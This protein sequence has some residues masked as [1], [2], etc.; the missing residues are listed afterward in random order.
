MADTQALEQATN[1]FIEDAERVHKIVNGD[2]TESVVTEDG[3]QIPTIRKAMLD[4]IYFKTPALPWTMGASATV[5]NQLYSYTD[6]NRGV[7]WWYAPTATASTPVAL[8]A[9]PNTSNSWRL[10]I[11]SNVMAQLYAPLA[12][13]IF[14]GNPQAPTPLENSNSTT[15]ATTQF[16][17]TAIANALSVA[18][19]GS[20]TYAN[21]TATGSI[22]TANLEVK[23]ATSF[24]G[25]VNGEKVDARFRNLFLSEQASTLTF[26]WTD[27]VNTSF[28]KTTLQPYRADIHNLFT[29]SISNGVASSDPAV[30]SFTGLGNNLMDYLRLTGNGERPASDPRLEVAGLTKLENVQITGTL[31]GVGFGVDGKDISPNSLNVSKE[32]EIGGSL[33]VLTNAEVDGTLT[34]GESLTV[35][36]LITTENLTATGLI[37]LESPVVTQ[38]M[39]ITSGDLTIS[40]GISVAGDVDLN[41][42]TGTTTVQNLVVKGSVSG[43]NFD[44]SGSD[45]VV[46]SLTSRTD[47]SVAGDLAVSG[48]SL[49]AEQDSDTGLWSGQTTVNDLIIQGAVTGLPAPDIT[50]QDISVSDVTAETLTVGSVSADK[51][52]LSVKSESVSGD[53]TPDGSRNIYYLTL[54][55]PLNLGS[56]P[57]TPGEAFTAFVYIQQDAAGSWAVTFDPAYA[58]LN[59]ASINGA[60]NSVT[61]LQVVYCGVGTVLDL[62]VIPRP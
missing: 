19:N 61:I 34:V 23:D 55:G 38:G 8:P 43:I 1:Q 11:D 30:V 6:A 46:N 20:V 4:N 53:Y 22:S 39:S 13:P 44:L 15:V 52:S 45:L 29:D 5:F 7:Q 54:T 12:S 59:Q 51:M 17:V 14:T 2:S 60:E 31:T 32:A 3:S 21:I 58:R 26:D 37:S 42:A 33:H 62:T 49:L 57:V 9:N 35:G 27:A 24:L 18:G 25:P 36:N 56:I 40:E 28:K 16:V 10:Y 50:G 41:G 47:L 48:T